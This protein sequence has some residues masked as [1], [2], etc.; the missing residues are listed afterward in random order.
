MILIDMH[1]L[2]YLNNSGLRRKISFKNFSE[3]KAH[4]IFP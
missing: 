2:V 1:L 4:L 3:T